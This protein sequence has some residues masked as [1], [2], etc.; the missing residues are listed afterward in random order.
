MNKLIICLLFLL[1]VTKI[2]SLELP[3]WVLNPPQSD[4]INF[5]VG[6][7]DK[8]SNFEFEK[9]N[10]FDA[11]CYLLACQDD[12]IVKSEIF[13]VSG[14]NE[15][16]YNHV[17]KP[18]SLKIAYYKKNAIVIESYSDYR[19]SYVLIAT[20]NCRV[21]TKMIVVD[22]INFPFETYSLEGSYFG[23]GIE[24]YSSAV[25][26]IYS[27]H[28]AITS[29]GQQIKSEVKSVYFEKNDLSIRAVNNVSELTITGIK[30]FKHYINYDKNIFVTYVIFKEKR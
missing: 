12:I 24:N 23:Y 20:Q 22:Q 1:C 14:T 9:E 4:E 16:V 11:G 15:V 26:L 25:G 7:S 10:A 2:L 6:I 27:T 28:S 18:D 17:V 3:N 5:A 19:F 13:E 30:P 21:E 8:Y 29:L